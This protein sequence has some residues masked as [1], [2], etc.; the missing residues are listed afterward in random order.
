MRKSFMVKSLSALIIL[1]SVGLVESS[2]NVANH[3]AHAEKNVIEIQDG[4]GSP[5]NSLIA[6][7]GASGFIVG[8]N[9]T[10]T[11]KHVTKYLKVGDKA[12]AHPTS[13]GNTGGVYTVTKIVEYSGKEDL[14]IVHVDG[15]SDLGWEFSRYTSPMPLASEA[16]PGERV[17]LIGYPYS[18]KNKY[19][20]YASLG[21]VISV[22]DSKVTYDAFAEPGNSGGPIMNQKGEAIGVHFASDKKQTPSKK[23]Y[24]VYFNQEIKDFI[25]QQIASQ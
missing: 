4:F 13:F 21:T 7:K 8:K 24:G 15:I 18:T 6:F 25:N 16:H 19:K 3:V 9:T 10:V 1:S 12:N 17:T 14:A 2:A 23:S 20:M 22:D 5:Y 11:N